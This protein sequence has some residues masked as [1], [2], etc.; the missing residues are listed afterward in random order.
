ME[1]TAAAGAQ[2]AR[3]AA[4]LAQGA[5]PTAGASAPAGP[6]AG[7]T[8]ATAPSATGQ[9]AAGQS[10]AAPSADASPAP[11]SAAFADPSAGAGSPL[12][13][14]AEGAPL[15]ADLV[16]PPADPVGPFGVAALDRAWDLAA[17]GGPVMAVLGAMSV[18][19]L[20]IV[21]AK[22]AQFA[23][24]GLGRRRAARE[25]LALAAGGRAEAALARARAA[26]GPTAGAL[27]AALAARLA[28]APEAAAREAAW[29][30]GARAVEALRAWTRPVE[31]I[32][33]LAPLL[34][35]FGTVLG[36]I[37]AFAR[38]EQA[39]A[40]VDPSVLS[41]GIWEALLTT[42]AGLAVAIPAVAAATWLERRVERE[43]HLIEV[44]LAAL[45]SGVAL[46]RADMLRADPAPGEVAPLHR[47]ER[48]HAAPVLRGV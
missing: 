26:G 7:P 40:N 19:G 25:T 17:A 29:T 6:G 12:A 23:G 15:P 44:S 30:E 5:A 28:G 10:A 35:L 18:A 48:A 45:F 11:S 1:P 21:L 34:G 27:A 37:A 43:E 4:Q 9:S 32:A 8:S 22:T 41:G 2:P 3:D 36:M 47:P 38:M 46:P 42:A 31:T 24:A 33:N 20:A 39:G 13:A 16:A 14:G